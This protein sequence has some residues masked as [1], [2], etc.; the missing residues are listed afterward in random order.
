[1]KNTSQKRKNLEQTIRAGSECYQKFAKHFNKNRKAIMKHEDLEQWWNG[2]KRAINELLGE[3]KN[4]KFNDGILHITKNKKVQL[5]IPV[6]YYS[7]QRREATKHKARMS[8]AKYLRGVGNSL[9]E[10]FNK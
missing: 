6:D 9:L 2:Y 3:E 7:H 1:M 5:I 10:L 4:Y 8:W